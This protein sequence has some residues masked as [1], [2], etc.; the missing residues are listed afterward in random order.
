M[1]SAPSEHTF[2]TFKSL[3][4]RALNE[5]IGLFIEL[6]NPKSFEV[7]ISKI[8]A[9]YPQYSSLMLCWPSLENTIFL[10]K[11]SVELI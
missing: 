2:G 10:M 6:E 9:I 8:K 3:L 5:D 4:D 11:K 1:T 7:Q